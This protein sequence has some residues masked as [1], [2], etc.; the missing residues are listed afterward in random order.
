MRA[1]EAVFQTFRA[2]QGKINAWIACP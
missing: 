2:V 1:R